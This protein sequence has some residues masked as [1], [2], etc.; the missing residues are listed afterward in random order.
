MR[1]REKRQDFETRML[2]W[3]MHKILKKEGKDK[4]DK[5]MPSSSSGQV[6]RKAEE[7]LQNPGAIE[8]G[9]IAEGNLQDPV[10]SQDG[11]ML[12]S[13]G[14]KLKRKAQEDL[15]NPEEQEIKMEDDSAE[16]GMKIGGMRSGGAGTTK[17]AIE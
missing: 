4:G 14:G 13:N 1:S 12:S 10:A 7:G 17:M 8:D 11:N 2:E 9:N 3:Q 15:P 6:K 5:S 16:D